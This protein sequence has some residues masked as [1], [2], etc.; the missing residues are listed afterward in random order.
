MHYDEVSQ[1]NVWHKYREILSYIHWLNINPRL[2][3]VFFFQMSQFVTEDVQ[4]V[5]INDAGV[6]SHPI[7]VAV[8][9]PDQI[10]EV[11]DVISY[12]KVRSSLSLFCSKFGN[13]R[14]SLTS[15]CIYVQS[16]SL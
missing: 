7:I 14:D 9:S 12:S 6:Y 16:I 15:T 4:T 8:E 11:F 5:M 3:V 13:K 10:N 1:N 2:I